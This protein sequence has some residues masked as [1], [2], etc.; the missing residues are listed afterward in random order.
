M[1]LAHI[2][3]LSPQIIDSIEIVAKHVGMLVVFGVDVLAD[4]RRQRQLRRLAKRQRQNVAR[5]VPR[6]EVSSA[7]RG[8]I[9][10]HAY[11]CNTYFVSI[12]ATVRCYAQT[13]VN[14]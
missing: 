10:V 8:D 2:H 1:R 12:L 4:G 7:L 5:P 14:L 11:I 13:R 6:C 9:T 3:R